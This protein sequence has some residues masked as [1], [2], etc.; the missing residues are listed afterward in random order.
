MVQ[1][2][3][4]IRVVLVDD[5]ALVRAGLR[6]I[7]EGDATIEIVGEAG[8]GVAAL[9]VVDDTHPDVVL[10]DIRMPQMDGL[11]ATEQMLRAHPSTKVVVL[12]SYDVD[13]L[14]PRALRLGA[15]GYFLKDTPPQELVEAVHRIADGDTMLSQSAI[16]HLVDAVTRQAPGAGG[17]DA[18]R[19]ADALTERELS[20]ARAISRGLSNA[21]IATE[22]FVSV[23]TVKTHVSRI[24]GKLGVV[25]RVQ[26]AAC[27]QRDAR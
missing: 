23:T 24:L 10:M 7:L 3:S 9:A 14:V 15:T 8:D 25:N 12:T 16:G 26:I 6:M 13:D 17:P 4:T 2:R 5:E 1:V 22:L 18:T 27:V 19:L 11:A 20:V 21:Q